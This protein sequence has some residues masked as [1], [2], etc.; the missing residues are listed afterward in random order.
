MSIPNTS[1]VPISVD[2]ALIAAK[3]MMAAYHSERLNEKNAALGRA[4]DETV[5]TWKWPFRRRLTAEEAYDL[6][7]R[8]PDNLAFADWSFCGWMTAGTEYK[9][10]SEKLQAAAAVSDTDQVWLDLDTAQIVST[11]IPKQK[12][13]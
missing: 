3:A 13:P 4:L 1:L 9:R 8:V 12:L 5:F 6:V 10:L 11:F 7:D 2:N